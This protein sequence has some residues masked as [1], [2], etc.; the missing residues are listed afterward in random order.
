MRRLLLTAAPVCAVALS[1]GLLKAQNPGADHWPN[2]QHNSNFSSL[3]QITPENVARL[4]QAWTFN[5]G[6]GTLATYP[7][8]ALDYRFQ[9]QPLLVGGVLYFSTPSAPDNRMP[10]LSS[11][12]TALEPETGKVIWQ[13]KS[14][15]HIHGRGIAYWKGNGTVGP[16]LYVGHRQGLHH[17]DRR[18]DRAT[19]H[20]VRQRT[21]KWMRMSAS[22]QRWS[23]RRLATRSPFRIPSPSTRTC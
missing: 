22:R 5:S 1:I 11:T 2:Y 14:P 3:T 21:A 23:A 10:G 12:V 4:T 18:Q 15:R 13:Y 9:V 8:V 7:F 6:A 20:R 17:R 16:R 19:G